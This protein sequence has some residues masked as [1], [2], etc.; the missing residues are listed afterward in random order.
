METIKRLHSAGQSL[1]MDHVAREQIRKGSLMQFIDD[2]VVSGISLTPQAV[3]QTLSSSQIYD[4]AIRKKLNEN[5]CGESLV[6]DL[7]LEDTHRAADLLR[8]VFDRTDG[9]DGWVN[10]PVSPLL[11]GDSDG[12]LKALLELSARVMRPNILLTVAGLP[13]RLDVI[14]EIVFA[15][16]PINISLI[17]SWDQYQETTEAYLRGIERRIAA[18]LKPAVSAFISISIF[19]LAA[20]LEKKMTQQ[21]TTLLSIAVARK[22]YKSMM[23][24]HNSQQWERAYSSG[25]RPLRLAWCISDDVDGTASNIPLYDHLMAP[26][27]VASMSEL[28][29][30]DFIKHGNPREPMPQNGDNC[31]EV[32]DGYQK[33]G[34]NFQQL[35]NNMQNEAAALQVKTWITMLDTIARRSASLMQTKSVI[36]TIGEK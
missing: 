5:L 19:Q 10:L 34:H 11:M 20:V 25:A 24:L 4:D 2:G 14:E 30:A 22:I 35:T 9:V 15:G 12:L 3:Y 7:I 32:L 31:E 1:W 18:G 36:S 17:Y 8:H 26:L 13:E 27:T 16:V 29:I 21:E 23:S 6:F 33:R 28:G